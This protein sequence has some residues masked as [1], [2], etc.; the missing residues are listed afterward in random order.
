MPVGTRSFTKVGAK[1][2]RARVDPSRACSGAEVDP[3]TL[4]LVAAEEKEWAEQLMKRCAHSAS[5]YMGT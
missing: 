4:F 5:W 2:L 1:Q 3:S